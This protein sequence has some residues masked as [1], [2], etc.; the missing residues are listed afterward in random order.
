MT[1]FWLIAMEQD[2][3]VANLRIHSESVVVVDD[4][5]HVVGFLLTVHNVCGL[6]VGFHVGK[7]A[8]RG[9]I[10][11]KVGCNVLVPIVL[12]PKERQTLCVAIHQHTFVLPCEIIHR[13]CIQLAEEIPTNVRAKDAIESTEKD[14]R[15]VHDQATLN[16]INDLLAGL[17]RLHKLG[18]VPNCV[19][20][21]WIDCFE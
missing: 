3:E 21:G 2:G 4:Q 15:V 18:V 10:D 13:I 11:H 14:L 16:Q 8:T 5:V 6:E 20:H 9:C 17:H 7:P 1:S 12:C 19:T